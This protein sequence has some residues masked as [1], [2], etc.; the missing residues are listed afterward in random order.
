MS[1]ISRAP[2]PPT[3]D[4][5]SILTVVAVGIS[6]NLLSP[7]TDASPPSKSISSDLRTISPPAPAVR[8]FKNRIC[9]LTYRSTDA[10]DTAPSK[11]VTNVPW[12]WE[13]TPLTSTAASNRTFLASTIVRLPAKTFALFLTVI[14]PV[15][16]D[17]ELSISKATFPAVAS[18]SFSNVMESRVVISTF[19]PAVTSW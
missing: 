6:I 18:R 17:W 11:R 10:A 16:P 8:V 5:T 7:E 9:W 15:V 13:S 19:C 2:V 12:V 14:K 1:P 3:G 4:P